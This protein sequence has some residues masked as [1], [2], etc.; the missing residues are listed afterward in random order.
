MSENSQGR[1]AFAF[2]PFSAGSRNCIGQRF[3]LME[4]KVVISW[5]LRNFKIE[6][7]QRRDEVRLKTELILRPIT[8]I[9]LK[10]VPRNHGTPTIFKSLKPIC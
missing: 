7:L 5:V 9:K 6:S 2:V 10:M 1:H 4:E 3:A 8:G